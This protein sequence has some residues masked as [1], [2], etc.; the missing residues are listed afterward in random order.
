MPFTGSL[1]NLWPTTLAGRAMLAGVLVWFT[2]WVFTD[3][4]SWL[5]SETLKLLIDLA[6]LLALIPL[7]YWI[8]RGTKWALERVL[9]RL[10]WRLILTYLLIGLLPLLLLVVLCGLIGYALITETSVN[11]TRRQL[12]VYLME[13]QAAARSFGQELQN[14]PAEFKRLLQHHADALAP[15]FPEIHLV[16]QAG[17]GAAQTARGRGANQSTASA[18]PALQAPQWL[19]AR[20][21]FHGLV[22]ERNAGNVRRVYAY[23]YLKLQQNEPT[24]LQMKYPVDGL[25]NNLSQTVGLQVLAG[26]ALLALVR[27]ARGEARFEQ[28]SQAEA[29][30]FTAADIEGVPIYAQVSDWLSGKQF[31]GE[32]LRLD[33]SFLQPQQL[34]Q[35]LRQFRQSSAW[36]NIVF[37]VIGGIAV[38]FALLGLAAI[39]SAIVLTRSITRAV[40]HLYAGTQR[41]EA[42]DLQQE[43][44]VVGKDQL[45]ELT[46]S[47]NRMIHSLRALLRVS[48]EKER[49]DQEM[50]IA[51]EVQARLF[52]RELPPSVRLD[53]APGVCWPARTVSGDYF[54]YLLVPPGLLGLVVADVCGKGVS[55]ALMMANL[56]ANLRSQVQARHDLC[57]EGKH[58]VSGV[59]KQ[60]NQM[61]AASSPEASYVTLFY[62]E[63]D[64]RSALLHYTNAGHNPPLLLRNGGSEFERL[65]CG[66]TV[67][68]LFRDAGY[69][70]GVVQLRSGDLLLAYTDGLIEARDPQGEEFGEERVAAAVLQHTSEPAEAIKQHLLAAVSQWA[71]GVEREDD[72]TLLVCKCR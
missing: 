64:E 13:S 61:I 71:Q 50:K 70:E 6:S 32:V 53:L 18:E 65:E 48:A 3:G 16:A 51:A 31:E 25:C 57:L 4:A 12:E 44:Q 28:L 66:G 47:F 42:G 46:N 56:Q 59:V 35:G 63:F 62:A 30:R 49:L 29:G 54:D 22:V 11:S 5:G 23:H 19:G 36:G 39:A 52:P 34:W 7:A 37:W 8:Y 17:A 15:I 33:M 9:W 27:N 43:I 58:S 55:A 10:R 68:G 67:V 26:H 40:H 60:L 69:D 72:L 2:N 45:G 21:E 1:K 20:A 38:V 41:V 14:D 24:L